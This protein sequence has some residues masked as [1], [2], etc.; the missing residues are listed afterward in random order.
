MD[1][2]IGKLTI[3]AAGIVVGVFLMRP[4]SAQQS[5]MPGLRLNHVGI[6]AKDFD[7]S[8]RFY[9]KIMGFREA[10][11]LKDKDGNPMITYLQISRDTFL[12]LAPANAQRPAGL[13][14]VGIWPDDLNAT[15]AELRRRGVKV[16]DPRITSSKSSIT[17]VVDPNEVRLELLN[18]LPDSLQ[19]KAID[20]W[21]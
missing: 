19:R 2:V 17:N 10:F 1:N 5:Q 3:F 4:G 15:V 7:E 8:M 18:I 21:R 6:Y 13:S 12:E 11:S 14:H 20:S 9:T 16:D